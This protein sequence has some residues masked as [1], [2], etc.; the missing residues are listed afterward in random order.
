MKRVLSIDILRGLALICMALIHFMIYLGNAAAMN[1]W[2]YF[3]LNHVLGDWG[4]ACFLMMMG[5]S[6]VLSADNLAPSD[7]HLFQRA[8]IRGGYIFLIG[9]IMLALSWGPSDI[10][11]WDIL[12]LMGVMTVILFV[13]RFLPSSLILF[14][15]LLIAVAT[16]SLRA[17]IDFASAWGGQFVQVPVISA[18]LPGIMLDP[19]ADFK[20]VWSI[21]DILLG[22]LLTGEFPIF[23]WALFPPIGFVIGRRIV[24]GKIQHDLPFLIIIGGVLVFLGIGGAYASLFRPGSS[25]ISDYISPLSFYPDSFTIIPY[26]LGMSLLAFSVLYFCYDARKKDPSQVSFLVSLYKRASRFSLTF[27][28]MHYLF[29]GWP[30]AIIALLTGRHF[31]YALL[32]TYPA[33]IVGLAGLTLLQVILYLWEK[34]GSKYSLE[35]WL[36]A[37]TS[38][39]TKR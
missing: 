34:Y 16:P 15:C 30:L 20:V 11:K 7:V 8:L 22:F 23:P 13:C 39:L 38:R 31:K 4:A 37:L 26:Q 9:V 14:I 25:V 6:Q 32:D 21:R 28:F 36:S 10:W 17:G 3:F 5:M 27:Y 18:Y 29:I 1:T 35:W 24:S 33:L 12:T 19:A 2:P